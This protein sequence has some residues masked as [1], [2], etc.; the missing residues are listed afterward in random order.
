[1]GPAKLG[2]EIVFPRFGFGR[3]G[4]CGF[5]MFSVLFVSVFSVEFCR[6]GF[7]SCFV[8]VSP[9]SCLSFC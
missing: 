9:F 5:G 1:M 7:V 2:S 4:I 6:S 8:S 3:D